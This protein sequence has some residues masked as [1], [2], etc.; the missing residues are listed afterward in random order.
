MLLYVDVY[1]FENFEFETRQK[2]KRKRE[3]E[4]LYWFALCISSIPSQSL[5]PRET[6][7]AHVPTQILRIQMWAPHF[8]HKI[9]GPIYRSITVPTARVSSSLTREHPRVYL[10]PPITPKTLSLPCPIN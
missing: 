10:T 3:R 1:L 8:T 2:R 4:N 9:K 5:K 6:S 7:L